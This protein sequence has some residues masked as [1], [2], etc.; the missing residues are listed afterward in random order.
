VA[1]RNMRRDVNETLKGMEKEKQISEDD[2]KKS[3]DEVQK[4]TDTF[5]KKVDETLQHKENEIMEV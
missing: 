5:V 2:L 3:L 4:I 1:I